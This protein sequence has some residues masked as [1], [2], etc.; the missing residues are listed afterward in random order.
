MLRKV[1]LEALGWYSFSNKRDSI[2]A[3]CKEIARQENV[4]EIV[5]QEALK[6]KARILCGSND[7]VNP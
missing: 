7:P 5:R 6:T 1:C 2:I 3:I 4:P